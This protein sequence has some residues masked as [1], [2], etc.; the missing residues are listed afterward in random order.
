MS[1]INLHLDS[2]IDSPK[3]VSAEEWQP[4]CNDIGEGPNT[5]HSAAME[6]AANLSWLPSKPLSET[7]A[8]RCQNLS[9]AFKMLFE[10]VEAAFAKTPDS[11]DLLWLRNNAQQLSSTT[12]LV[13]SE[14]TPLTLP[15]VSNNDQIQPRVLAIAEAFLRQTDIA[16]SKTT[17]T[18]FCLAF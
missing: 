13:A 1:R 6:L 8:N 14:L 18:A 7:F 5:M 17:F 9:A 15:V 16:V 11:E 2:Q 4:S 12:R 3:R 10:R